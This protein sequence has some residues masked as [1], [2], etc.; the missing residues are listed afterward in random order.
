MYF[1]SQKSEYN[2][3]TSGSAVTDEVMLREEMDTKVRSNCFIY[4]L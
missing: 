4:W 2:I 3:V 1:S